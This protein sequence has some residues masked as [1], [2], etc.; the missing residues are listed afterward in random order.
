MAGV[1]IGALA[2]AGCTTASTDDAA[3]P[4][5][6]APTATIA[7]DAQPTLAPAPQPVVA[8]ASPPKPVLRVTGPEEVVFDWTTDQCEPE[9]IPD[10]APRA[11]RSPDGD[12]NLT[13]GHWSTWRMVGPS[14]DELT[15]DCSG[16]LI[17]S[18]Y[19]PDPG[20]FDDSAWLAAVYTVD[21][22]T[23]HGIVH[24]E[25]RGD[26][27]TAA[28]PGQCPSGERLPCLDTSFTQV[29]SIDGGRTFANA[30]PPPAH[31]VATLPYRYS[32]DTVPSGIRQ[33][34]NIIDGRDGYWYLF[35]NVSDQPAEE[36]W[37]CAMRTDDLADPGAWRYWDGA[38]FEGIWGD[39]YGDAELTADRKCAPY[40]LDTIGASL[41]EGIVYD[42]SIQR[43]VIV[44]VGFDPIGS[45]PWGIYTSTSPDLVEW[46]TREFLLEVPVTPTI[47]GPDDLQYAYPTLIDPDSD[48]PNFE[49]SDGE[50]YLYMSRFNFGGNSLDRDLVRWPVRFD[51]V[52]APSVDWT[53][54]DDETGGWIADN[55]LAAPA[56]TDG[57]LVT[58]TTGD[59]PWMLS[60]RVALDAVP[61]RLVV[62]MRASGD[63]SLDLGQLF[64]AVE[65]DP[66]YIE[67]RSVTFDVRLDGEWHDYVVDLSDAFGWEGTITSL[68]LDP[69]GRAGVRIEVDRIVIA[70]P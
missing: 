10:I 28:R 17:T 46:T 50:L 38:G 6:A 60:P 57:R 34:S 33:P 2:A 12:V 64:W 70:A 29:V 42:A 68:R 18:N 8:L 41:N 55:D 56:I 45:D 54:D 67:A 52:P 61:A 65:G 30:A 32:D 25:Y 27:H 69:M 59:D 26:T 37:V 21:G 20:A 16:P 36:Q 47:S 35:G 15:T 9:H 40:A 39:P 22:E 1:L 31:L 7:A 5:S 51:E 14:L 44:G 23:Y 63:A 13:I 66:A 43:F 3:T 24:N 4:T 49:T 62:R 53:F 11:F 58:E 48:S 19:D